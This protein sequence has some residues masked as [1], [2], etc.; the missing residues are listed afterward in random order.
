M[1][2][3]LVG[4]LGPNVVN[5]VMSKSYLWQ[6]LFLV[7]SSWLKL[8]LTGKDFLTFA[9]GDGVNRKAAEQN[10]QAY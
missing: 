4:A 8:I 5:T 3:I 10:K 7:Q 2:H 9:V 1:A 6:Q